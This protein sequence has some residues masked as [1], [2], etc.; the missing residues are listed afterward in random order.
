MVNSSASLTHPL[1]IALFFIACLTGFHGQFVLLGEALGLWGAARGYVPTI[2]LFGLIVGLASA[3]AVRRAKKRAN[4]LRPDPKHFSPFGAAG[5]NA[6]LFVWPR[7]DEAKILED[8]IIKA[9]TSNIIVTGPSGAGKSTILKHIVVP[10]LEAKGYECRTIQTYNDFVTDIL[11]TL[12]AGTN[13]ELAAQGKKLKD[14]VRK[15]LSTKH[16]TIHDALDSNGE[17]KKIADALW[18]QIEQY[19]TTSLNSSAST[20]G[21]NI[22]FI[23]DQVERLILNAKS[24]VISETKVSIRDNERDAASNGY[25]L[26]LFLRVFKF[27]RKQLN[28]RTVFVVRSEYIY[29][30]FELVETLSRDNNADSEKIFQYFL[31][32]GIN[33][34]SANDAV[35]EVHR[36]FRELTQ[37]RDQ[38]DDFREVC[39]IGNR[40]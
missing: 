8:R 4:E 15:F 24:R 19:L 6:S 36:R 20:D 23:F 5:N 26:V 25:E 32:P 14:E 40:S 1:V 11:D 12:Y 3:S 27:L 33:A 39:K 16:C 30:I 28:I 10:R 35:E 17:K 31:C 34:E 22:L 18:E 21:S 2:L 38:W 37:F 9:Y 13:T 7:K 29:N